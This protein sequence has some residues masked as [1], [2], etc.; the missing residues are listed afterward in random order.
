[1]EGFHLK[2]R[3]LSYLVMRRLIEVPTTLISSFKAKNTLFPQIL[4]Y[5]SYADVFLCISPDQQRLSWSGPPN[6]SVSTL[7]ING[8]YG[9]FM[10]RQADSEYY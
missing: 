5:T 7:P 9:S 6:T 4:E 8:N 3:I 2:L 1:M 10:C